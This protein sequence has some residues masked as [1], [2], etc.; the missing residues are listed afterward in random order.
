[1]YPPTGKLFHVDPSRIRENI[2]AISKKTGVEIWAVIKADAYGLGAR[3]IAPLVA[4]LV[5]GFCFF[6]LTEAIDADIWNL[7]HKPSITLGPPDTSDPAI[8]IEHHVRPAVATVE[9]A[10]QLRSADPILCIDTGMHRF[11]CAPDQAAAA[12]KAGGCRE[13]FTHATCMEH[14][15]KLRQATNGHDLK[16][17]AAATALLDEPGAWMDAVRPGLA[18]YENAIRVTTTLH[19]VHSSPG[20][21]GYTGFSTPRHGVIVVGYSNG[22][23]RGRCLINGQSRRILEVGMQSAYVEAG[24]EDRAGDEVVLLG[25]GLTPQELSPQWGCS[26]HEVVY[27]FASGGGEPALCPLK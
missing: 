17:H 5:S 15:E 20:P 13:A 9:Q 18:M 26:P 10:R 14:V 19:E 25:E 24:A 2:Q 8:Y 4:D 22:L 21:I 1:M 12:L 16:L 3:V 11:A 6:R 27:R 7:T 23:R